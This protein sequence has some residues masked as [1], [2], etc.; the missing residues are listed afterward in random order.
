MIK[1]LSQLKKALTKGAEFDVV[2]H[3]RPECI[4]ERRR[5]NYAD[6]T[7]FYSIL[8]NDPNHKSNNS[9]S[10]KGFFLSWSK[11]AFWEFREDGVCA[12]YSSDTHRTSEYL[13]IAMKPVKA[14]GM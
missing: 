14:G 1:N 11:A 2:E 3:C 10:G 8:P 7:G 5:I 12:T 9:N 13:T 6:T 4:G